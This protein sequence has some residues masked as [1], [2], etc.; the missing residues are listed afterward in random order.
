MAVWPE[1]L[2]A[3]Q[4]SLTVQAGTNVKRR[5][6][7]SGRYEARRFGSGKPDTKKVSFKLYTAA[8]VSAFMDFFKGD[9]NLGV[10]WFSAYW[11][12]SMGYDDH[13]ARILGY[14][15]RRAKL[16]WFSI[17]EATLL[18]QQTE[19]CLDDST[20][21]VDGDGG[22][23][24]EPELS[25]ITGL[26]RA[27]YGKTINDESEW[28]NIDPD[29]T[30]EFTEGDILLIG[31]TGCNDTEADS[32]TS[33]PPYA[34]VK[35]YRSA[36]SG[37]CRRYV[38]T[39]YCD[40]PNILILGDKMLHALV[41]PEGSG[42]G[43]IIFHVGF[44]EATADASAYKFVLDETTPLGFSVS[45]EGA[46]CFMVGGVCTPEITIPNARN[47]EWVVVSIAYEHSTGIVRG[48]CNGEEI[49]SVVN[50][51]FETTFPRLAM[52]AS[53][54]VSNERAA[55]KVASI[56]IQDIFDESSHAAFK[57]ITEEWWGYPA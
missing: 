34:L 28:H 11:L 18:I 2:P 4:K 42:S 55:C 3:P 21:Q 50:T 46:I 10:N 53:R 35:S 41:K 1:S 57:Q 16:T 49:Y 8:Q 23:V 44:T 36:N 14:P 12:E 33:C 24:V 52:G 39:K 25:G 51:S 19:Y 37:Y 48:Y 30:V 56:I 22:D 6:C 43:E 32:L 5:Q 15:K 7:Q 40:D 13:K 17:Y 9:A 27:D 31:G 54:S 20:W 29:D 38:V 45:N 26:W 47:D